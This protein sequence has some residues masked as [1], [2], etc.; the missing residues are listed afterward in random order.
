MQK[1]IRDFQHGPQLIGGKANLGEAIIAFYK[2]S[3][4]IHPGSLAMTGYYRNLPIPKLVEITW[5]SFLITLTSS[6]A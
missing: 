3:R 6:K 5:Q 2:G 4:L 1:F